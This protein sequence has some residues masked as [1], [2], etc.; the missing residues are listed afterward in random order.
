MSYLRY[1]MVVCMLGPFFWVGVPGP[2]FGQWYHGGTLH[3]AH[4][5]AWQKADA[6][7]RLATAADLVVAVTQ[8]GNTIIRY[9]TVEDLRPY[10]TQLAA[11]ITEATKT[12]AAATLPVQDIAALCVGS[13]QWQVK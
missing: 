8:G 9:Q 11:C 3:A 5:L 6:S 4:G 7:N 2:V 12:K 13:L 1:A 10:A